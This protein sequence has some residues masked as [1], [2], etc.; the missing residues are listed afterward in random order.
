MRFPSPFVIALGITLLVFVAGLFI[1]INTG[2]SVQLSIQEL[3]TGWY[4]GLGDNSTGGLHFAFQMMLILVLGHVLALTAS[5]KSVISRLTK[6]CH[7]SSQAAVIICVTAILLG[8]LNWGLA[9]VFSALLVKQVLIKLREQNKPVNVGLLGTAAY[10]SM[11]V[12]HGGFSGSSPL[13]ASEN[14]ALREMMTQAGYAA[15][16][17]VPIIIETS[18]TLFS[19]LNIFVFFCSLVFIPLGLYILGEKMKSKNKLVQVQEQFLEAD[20]RFRWNGAAFTGLALLGIALFLAFADKQS[21][22]GFLN[23]NFINLCLLGLGILLHNSFEKFTRIVQLAIQDA[24]GILIQF[25]IYFGIIGLMK[26]SGLAHMLSDSLVSISTT[27]T[28]HVLSFLSAG[29]LNFFIPSGGGQ[30]YIQGP[31]LIQSAIELGVSVPKTIMALSY[32]DQWTNMLQPFWAL[33]ILGITKIKLSELLPYC[34][35]LFLI[36]GVIFS[37][38]LI[39]L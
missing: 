4:D 5:F 35:L 14:H 25:P 20:R 27:E 23:I 26:V 36:S 28:F 22:G 33:P 37:V 32:G 15:N 1:K 30:F 19:D 13:K 34:F 6:Y 39:W 11:L 18:E 10:S 24:S 3:V 8:Y 17:E 21:P 2:H 9:L 29:L 16:D 7:T 12:W 31:M 38:A